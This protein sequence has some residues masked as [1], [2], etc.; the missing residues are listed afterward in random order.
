[1]TTKRPRR[2]KSYEELEAEARARQAWSR[3]RAR[4][5]EFDQHYREQGRRPSLEEVQT[6]MLECVTLLQSPS[7]EQLAEDSSLAGAQRQVGMLGPRNQRRLLRWLV[8]RLGE[9]V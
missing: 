3:A 5:R 9:E 8:D 4:A 7:A 1:M 2:R 6:T